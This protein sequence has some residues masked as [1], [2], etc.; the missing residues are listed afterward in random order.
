MPSS[1]SFNVNSNGLIPRA[2][3]PPLVSPRP[4]KVD[5]TGDSNTAAGRDL[6]ARVLGQGP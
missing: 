2:S 4:L 3:I 1:A 5:A 6:I